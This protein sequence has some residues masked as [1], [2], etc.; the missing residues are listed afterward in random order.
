MAVGQVGSRQKGSLHTPSDARLAASEDWAYPI[1][2]G[3]LNAGLVGSNP[4]APMRFRYP[5]RWA[6]AAASLWCPA[7]TSS[8]DLITGNGSLLELVGGF[9][10]VVESSVMGDFLGRGDP[11]MSG[12]MLTTDPGLGDCAVTF[13]VSGSYGLKENGF[14]DDDRDD[15]DDV[16]VVGGD[17]DDDEDDVLTVSETTIDGLFL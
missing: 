2:K 8:P 3:G 15:V 14:D 4:A 6:A 7:S 9:N 5:A 13:L 1:P 11:E 17:I 16:S 10:V 12:E